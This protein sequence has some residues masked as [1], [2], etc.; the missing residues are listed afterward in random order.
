M[1]NKSST[2]KR[3]QAITFRLPSDTPDHILKQLQKIK[4]KEK[5]NFSSTIARF[6]LEG[7]K[8]T[9]IK[10]REAI[11][12]PLPKQLTPEQKSWLRHSHSEMLIGTIVYELLQDP[13]KATALYASLN[14]KSNDL[15][16]SFDIHELQKAEKQAK[17]DKTKD[18]LDNFDISQLY[19]E[20]KQE[21]KEEINDEADGTELLS[22]FIAMMNK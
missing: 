10:D 12:I 22:D 5:R 18:D 21:E 8:N 4:E 16:Q 6:A 11:T 7:V 19:E 9:L 15:D 3:G 14:S 17:I 2:I 13:V 20:E 1:K